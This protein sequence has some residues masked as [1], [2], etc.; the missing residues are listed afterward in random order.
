LAQDL[1]GFLLDGLEAG[2][3]LLPMDSAK[4]RVWQGSL[5]VET[6]QKPQMDTG[7]RLVDF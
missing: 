5:D 6:A 1:D 7:F 4:R 2:S 3:F